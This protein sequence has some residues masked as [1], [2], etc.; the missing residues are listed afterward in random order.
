MMF[1]RRWNR[2]ARFRR[3]GS[4][5]KVLKE[6]LGGKTFAIDPARVSTAIGLRATP[7]IGW[8]FSGRRLATVV[9]A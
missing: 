1:S 7:R 9:A 3:L 2:I 8:K 6:I 4:V 5:P